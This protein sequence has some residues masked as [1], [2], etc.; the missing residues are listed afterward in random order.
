VTGNPVTF[1]FPRPYTAKKKG[2]IRLPDR[3]YIRLRAYESY[4]QIPLQN[5]AVTITATDGTAI[6]MG[7][8]NG[9]GQFGPVE[10]PVPELTAGLTPDTGVIPFTTV[11]VHA[12]RNGYEQ[13][14]ARD[15]QIFPNTVTYQ[16]LEMIP[17]SELPADR[18]KT[19]NFATP[20]Q[21]L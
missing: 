1:F 6:A 9:S 12:A 21:N 11:N 18:S 7:L 5:V 8:T 15:L 3:G 10:L 14:T 4:A 19:E 2:V 17:L 13:I 20:P 16:D